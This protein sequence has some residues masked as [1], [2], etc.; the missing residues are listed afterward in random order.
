MYFMLKWYSI[1]TF[2]NLGNLL[3][4]MYYFSLENCWIWGRIIKFALFLISLV[5]IFKTHVYYHLS[6]NN[7]HFLSKLCYLLLV[8]QLFKVGNKVILF[9]KT[10]RLIKHYFCEENHW[11]QNTRDVKHS[12]LPKEFTAPELTEQIHDKVFGL[13]HIGMKK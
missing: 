13:N 6:I 12:G 4:I 7:C 10:E 5:V 9:W 2:L 1:V 8:W 3:L 11:N